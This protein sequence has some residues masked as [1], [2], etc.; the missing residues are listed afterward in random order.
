MMARRGEKARDVTQFAAVRRSDF[1]VSS[2]IFS[3]I[4]NIRT[5]RP[6]SFAGLSMDPLR[7][8]RQIRAS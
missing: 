7:D 6:T 1:V 4:R 8:I 2:L 5:L 3:H